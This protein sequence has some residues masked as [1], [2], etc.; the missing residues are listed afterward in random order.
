MLLPF[1]L[2]ISLSLGITT[3]SDDVDVRTGD[4][5]ATDAQPTMDGDF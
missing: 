5:S 2:K 1:F 4:V 3:D